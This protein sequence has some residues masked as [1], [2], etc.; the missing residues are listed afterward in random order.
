MTREKYSELK[1]EGNFIKVS[2]SYLTASPG[3]LTNSEYTDTTDLTVTPLKGDADSASY[4]VLRHSN[5]ASRASTNYKL[6]VPSSTGDLT[7]PQMGGTLSLHGR[8][9]KIHVVDYDVA[10]TKLLYSTAEIFTWKKFDDKKV[11]VLYGGPNEHHEFAVSHD[12]S[13]KAKFSMIE[14]PESGFAA[15][16]IQRAT[17]ISWD[18]SPKRR[19]VEVEDLTVILLDRNSA[20]N[21]WV[22]ELPERGSSPGLPTQEKTARSIIVNAGY[23]VR[24]AFTK[25]RNLHITAD[26]NATTPIE[27]IGAPSFAK[28]L[29]IN[30]ERVRH[31]VNKHGFWTTKVDYSAPGIKLPS[32]KD[33]DW[34]YV[35][36]LPEI[37]SE[38]DDSAWTVA[39][40][41]VTNNTL[42]PL[43][44][45]TS[46]YSSDY[47]YHTGYLIYRGHFDATGDETTFSVH[48]QGGSAYGHSVWLGETHLGSFQG[49][50]AQ[51]DFKATYKVP[52][53]AK[54]RS[55]VLTV[56]IDNMGLNE[57]WT[58][59]TDDMKHPRGILNYDL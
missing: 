41:P 55:Y 3:N 5:Y 15:R 57:D 36:S 28:H 16:D 29:F 8:D 46:L 51:S 7:L 39:D 11:L 38:Y 44:T 1:L 34:K 6:K 13:S 56:L 59:G 10:G 9:S 32:L 2:P 49:T 47:G 48:T 26:F 4:Y 30:D 25:G 54:G 37:Q 52:N 40:R 12:G 17:V 22:P 19:I 27:V 42:R 53:L 24:T 14:G 33:L 21:Y 45:P 43:D 23:L 31:A 35:D 50:A 58:V 20:Y 18:V